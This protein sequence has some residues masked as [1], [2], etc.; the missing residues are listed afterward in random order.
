MTKVVASEAT[1][2]PLLIKPNI[3]QIL[4]DKPN[5][6]IMIQSSLAKNGAL[7]NDELVSDE[8]FVCLSTFLREL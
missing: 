5:K 8:R 1:T 2:A 4:L 3:A 6:K 7:F